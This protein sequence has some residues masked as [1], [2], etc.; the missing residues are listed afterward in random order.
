MVRKIIIN[1]LVVVFVFGCTIYRE[2]KKISLK[3]IP[4]DFKGE[5]TVFYVNEVDFCINYLDL[6]FFD[7]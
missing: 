3:N 2:N 4:L 1:L 6:E 7:W 5:D